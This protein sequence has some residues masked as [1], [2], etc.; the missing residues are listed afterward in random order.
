[1]VILL[2]GGTNEM[3]RLSI[4]HQIKSAHIRY[5]DQAH[6]F[7]ALNSYVDGSFN[8]KMI[9]FAKLNVVLKPRFYQTPGT[10]YVG[11]LV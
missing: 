2:H 4:D 9:M 6:K 1:M 7:Q 8:T 10:S 5:Q 11:R 3:K